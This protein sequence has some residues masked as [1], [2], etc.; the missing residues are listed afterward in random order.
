MLLEF[1]LKNFFSFK[2]GI[3]V[4]FKLDENCPRSISLGKD[5]STVLCIKG[6]NASG[7]THLLKGLAFLRY[8]CTDSFSADPKAEIVIEPFFDSKEPCEFYVEFRV[9]QTTYL[10]ELVVAANGVVEEI[11]YRTISKRTK[12]FHRSQ[13]V[14]KLATKELSNIGSLKLRKNVSVIAL[15]H[16]YE[17]T[18]LQDL[19]AFFENIHPNVN[20][21]G[22]IEGPFAD[23]D[24]VAA[25]LHKNKSY[26][27]FTKKFISECDVGISDITIHARTSDIS[28][29][30]GTKKKYFPIFHHG[31]GGKSHGITR[32]TES[33]GTQALF[34]DL[35][36]Y[37]LTLLCG[38]VLVLDE[39]DVF[40]H[41]HILPKLL[42]L[43]MDPKLNKKNAQII[44]STHNSEILNDMGRYRTY[45]VNKHENESFAYRLD[46][47]QG[48]ILR[49]DRPIRPMYEDGKIGG[50]PRL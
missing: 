1:G 48:D 7:K 47:L 32:H 18:E 26:L 43:F 37:K 19:Y 24:T 50:V 49:N 44:F 21:A 8:F 5:F 9:K 30:S 12:I 42:K 20:F 28:A 29:D 38:G 6:A 25:I 23:V 3:S 39:F 33:S 27:E 45:L 14:V 31:S 13:N 41:P 11:I 15:A 17:L 4:S 2:E 34:A 22:R 16:Q 40:L 10:Y 46:E 35:L 36:L